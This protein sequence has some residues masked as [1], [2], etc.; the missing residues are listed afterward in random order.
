MKNPTEHPGRGR[1]SAGSANGNGVCC[2]VEEIRQQCCA[3]NLLQ[4]QPSRRLNVGNGVFDSRR[5]H[6]NLGGIGNAAAILW[7]QLDAQLAELFELLRQSALI[8]RTIG[9]FDPV[10]ARLHDQR[11]G[12]HAAATDAAKEIVLV[13][14]HGQRLKTV[15][16]LKND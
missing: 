14:G 16:G 8:E 9:T 1:F 11:Q 10:S 2:C 6:E 5:G 13:R 12:Q 7:M 3:G 4:T 15:T